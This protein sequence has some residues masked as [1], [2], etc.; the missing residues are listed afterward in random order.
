MD[1]AYAACDF[2]IGRAGATFLAE[3][4]AKKIP[5]ILIPY[6]YA[7]AHQLA[8]A[9]IFSRHN[10]AVVAEQRDLT[11]EKLAD[12]VSGYAAKT[13]RGRDGHLSNGFG[14]AAPLVNARTL[15]ADFMNETA[16]E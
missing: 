2:A 7:G 15:L 10:D 1:L 14:V 8:N 16:L 6:P 5:A 9:R 3:I 12:F 4:T 11:P 13:A